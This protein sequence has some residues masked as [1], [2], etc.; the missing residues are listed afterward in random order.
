MRRPLVVTVGAVL[1]VVILM[2][3]GFAAWPYL[4]YPGVMERTAAGHLDNVEVQ[5]FGYVGEDIRTAAVSRFWIL[6]EGSDNLASVVTYDGGPLNRDAAGRDF[7]S[8]SQ[9]EEELGWLPLGGDVRCGL[10]AFWMKKQPPIGANVELSDADW[11]S[12]EAGTVT[13]I[14]VVVTCGGG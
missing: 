5:G 10:T 8:R 12:V 4:K 11:R 2:V 13:L 3:L 6:R 1:A 7:P 9:F 14:R